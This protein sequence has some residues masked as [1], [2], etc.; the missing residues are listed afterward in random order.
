ME[1][2]FL[3]TGAVGAAPRRKVPA[4]VRFV[5]AGLARLAGLVAVAAAISA[6]IG[7]LVGWLKGSDL[8]HAANL[9]LYLGGAALVAVALLSAG[10]QSFS[11]GEYVIHDVSA[12][13]HA[14]RHHQSKVG[15]YALVG[16]LVLVLGAVVET[17][18]G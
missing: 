7:L 13:A 12:D 10:G 2:R 6:G 5:G 8:G 18:R 15:V 1:Q 4:Y 14:R 3:R 17:L 9:G 16:A 11:S